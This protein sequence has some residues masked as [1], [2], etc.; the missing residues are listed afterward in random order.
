MV[1]LLL[2]CAGP[3]GLAEF[4]YNVCVWKGRTEVIR[5]YWFWVLLSTAGISG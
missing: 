3:P 4:T 5:G 2:G 1:I